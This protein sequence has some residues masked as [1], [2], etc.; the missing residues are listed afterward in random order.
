MESNTQTLIVNL[1]SNGPY[2]SHNFYQFNQD[3]NVNIV[4]KNLNEEKENLGDFAIKK[5]DIIKISDVFADSEVNKP[6]SIGNEILKTGTD[7]DTYI[8]T[9]GKEIE[10]TKFTK[11]YV[12]H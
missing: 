2:L 1:S 9:F 10:Y 12:D 11:T 7:S 5:G 3:T 4:K 6:L 8:V